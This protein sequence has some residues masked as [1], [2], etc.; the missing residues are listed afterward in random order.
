MVLCLHKQLQEE[1]HRGDDECDPGDDPE[2][3]LKRLENELTT[4]RNAH[5][6]LGVRIAQLEGA[7]RYERSA[8]EMQ[9]RGFSTELET[10]MRGLI[11]RIDTG[12]SMGA[13]AMRERTEVT[14]VRLR[15]LIGRVDSSL[16]KIREEGL[17]S[18][19]HATAMM[20]TPVL[21]VLAPSSDKQ[22][23]SAGAPPNRYAM[24]DPLA[25]SFARLREQREQLQSQRQQLDRQ[26]PR[27][28]SGN[29]QR[30]V[31]GKSGRITPSYPIGPLTPSLAIPQTMQVPGSG[32]RTMVKPETVKGI[33]HEPVFS[34]RDTI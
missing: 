18:Q 26:V 22:A 5:E 23:V 4:E 15:S 1:C 30:R 33:L 17:P 31:S 20:P 2:S 12:L 8:R 28:I 7:I 27:F 25:E 10:T 32:L 16:S 13:S 29:V 11:G 21:D 34:P 6:A 14:E 3:L 24:S 19:P 9:L